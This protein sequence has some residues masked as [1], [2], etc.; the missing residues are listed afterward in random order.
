MKA[1][2]PSVI[3]LPGAVPVGEGTSPISSALIRRY[4]QQFLV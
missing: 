2:D 1:A 4:L 3:L